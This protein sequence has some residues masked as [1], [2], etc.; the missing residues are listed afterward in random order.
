[1]LFR[2][3][4]LETAGRRNGGVFKGKQ[5][6][7]F[8]LNIS[9]L[10][11]QLPWLEAIASL[12]GACSLGALFLRRK[13]RSLQARKDYV[14]KK[15]RQFKEENFPETHD[16][17]VKQLLNFQKEGK[18]KFILIDVRSKKERDVSIIPGALSPHDFEANRDHYEDGHTT[19]AYCTAGYRSGLYA[20]KLQENNMPVFN[21][22]GGVIAWALEGQIFTDSDGE[23]R[24]V[25][26]YNKNWD[27][28]SKEY[29]AVW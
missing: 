12:S 11:P 3:S 23:C 22:V 13:P 20:K 19:V 1:M 14:E 25:H 18:T 16:I 17:T 29:E 15:F 10:N 9:I 21:L 26:V 24:R 6:V 8:K 7:D 28:L 2:V 5:K 4:S 27:L